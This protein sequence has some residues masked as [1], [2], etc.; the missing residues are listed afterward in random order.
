MSNNENKGNNTWPM[1]TITLREVGTE[2]VKKERPSKRLSDA[3]FQTRKE[4]DLCF[5]CNEKF[6]HGHECKVR[7]QR[8]LR[9]VVVK[10]E[11]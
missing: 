7:E 3:E 2:E 6:S 4:K 1:R 8:K 9:M 11:D 10:S 5:R